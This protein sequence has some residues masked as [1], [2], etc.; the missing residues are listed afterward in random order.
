[1]RHIKSPLFDLSADTDERYPG[2]PADIKLKN[3]VFTCLVGS[4]NSSYLIGTLCDMTQRPPHTYQEHT[5][6][7]ISMEIKFSLKGKSWKTLLSAAKFLLRL[8]SAQPDP[9]GEPH[10]NRKLMVAKITLNFF[11]FKYWRRLFPKIQK[12]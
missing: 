2:G 3:A 10:E 8:S 4:G 9:S 12:S 5:C 6:K 11:T 7:R 1:M